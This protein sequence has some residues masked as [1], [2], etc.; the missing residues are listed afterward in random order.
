MS[1]H[2][3]SAMAWR[4][5]LSCFVTHALR[6]CVMSNLRR[7]D[8]PSS[9]KICIKSSFCHGRGATNLTAQITGL[10]RKSFRCVED[11][12][13]IYYLSSP[14]LVSRIH[15]LNAHPLQTQSSYKSP[16]IVRYA[17]NAT[18][19]QAYL[20]TRGTTKQRTANAK[21]SLLYFWQSAPSL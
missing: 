1:S 12:Y 10:D 18:A 7:K 19:M 2:S 6:P 16:G 21:D 20:L 3:M 13:P 11:I 14:A 8:V 5:H 17:L 9:R 15:T 4:E